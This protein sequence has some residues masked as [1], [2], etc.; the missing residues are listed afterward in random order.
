MV[1]ACPCTR[2]RAVTR[3]QH[4]ILLIH[5]PPMIHMV[6]V[7]IFLSS[8]TIANPSWRCLEEIRLGCK[9]RDSPKLFQV[10]WRVYTRAA[11]VTLRQDLDRLERAEGGVGG[12][13]LGA[14]VFHSVKYTAHGAVVLVSRAS[15]SNGLP[16]ERVLLV[17]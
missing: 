14:Q 2:G 6:S 10:A 7:S 5:H 3:R 9:P 17:V 12:C 15:M 13:A 1:A 8:I 11:L 4:S 16:T